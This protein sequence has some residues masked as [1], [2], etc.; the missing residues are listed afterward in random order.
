MSFLLQELATLP[1]RVTHLLF[2]LSMSVLTEL[3]STLVTHSPLLTSLQFA[4]GGQSG[5]S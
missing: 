3:R 5:S 4:F 2:P 1:H